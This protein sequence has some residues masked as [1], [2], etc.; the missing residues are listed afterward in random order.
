MATAR[1][2]RPRRPGS[3]EGIDWWSRLSLGCLGGCAEGPVG[4]CPVSFWVGGLAYFDEVAVG[5]ADV[6]AGLVLVLFGR[7][8][9]VGA[10][11]APCGVHGVDVFDPDIEEAADPVRVAWRLQGDRRL[12]VGGASAGVDDD[13]AVGQR[14]VG[15][16]AGT[17]ERHSAAED[18]GVEVPG[19]LDISGDNEVG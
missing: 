8:Q 6:A 18:F 4:G 9:E 1:S 15:Q 13:P 19:A 7:C 11:G 10:A 16:P 14:D 3:I 5:V 2:D 17:G 12:V